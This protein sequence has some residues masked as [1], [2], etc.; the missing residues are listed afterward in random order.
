MR[1]RTDSDENFQVRVPRVIAAGEKH[2]R[3]N[4]KRFTKIGLRKITSGY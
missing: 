1:V 2:I 4:I 3:K